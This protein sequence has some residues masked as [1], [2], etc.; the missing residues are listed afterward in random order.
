MG[1]TEYCSVRFTIAAIS[2]REPE[3]ELDVPS[4]DTGSGYGSS[5]SGAPVTSSELS[6][7]HRHGS[8][9]NLDEMP[10]AK[11]LFQ[12]L[13]EG[14]DIEDPRHVYPTFGGVRQ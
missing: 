7:S 12:E 14:I 1:V 3:N 9:D 4:A 13:V 2:G 11:T 10:T 6:R 8:V 5:S